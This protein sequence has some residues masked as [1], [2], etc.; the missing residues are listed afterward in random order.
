[1]IAQEKRKG[2]TRANDVLQRLREDIINCDLLPDQR[3]RFEALKERYAVSFSTLREALARLVAERLVISEGQRGFVVAPVS[4][5]DLIDL[6]NARVLL[7]RENLRLAMENGGDAWEAAILTGY[8]RMERLQTRLGERYYLS[9]EWAQLHGR[10]HA[11][12]VS[13]SNSP[14][15]LEIR[16]TL[17]ERAHRYRRISSQF[18]SQ[19]RPK[20]VEHK[21]I[22]DAALDRQPEALDLIERHIRETTENVLKLASGL[23]AP[24]KQTDVGLRVVTQDGVATHA[25]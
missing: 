7:D 2:D 17:F 8:Y 14:L 9:P 12:L 11:A 4:I 15:L 18:R 10:F 3:L 21:A 23:F 24:A 25:G 6:T 19:W 5:H 13:A 20:D 1:V 16:D 22:M